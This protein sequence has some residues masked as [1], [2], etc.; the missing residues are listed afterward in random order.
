MIEAITKKLDHI[1]KLWRV[2]YIVVSLIVAATVWATTLQIK[3]ANLESRSTS[4]D[5]RLGRI[6]FYV[7]RIAEKVGVQVEP[8]R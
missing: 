6:E 3:V 5:T 2:I 7:L 1:D 8:P 4:A